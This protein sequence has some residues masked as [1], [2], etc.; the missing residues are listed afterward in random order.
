V[1][2]YDGLCRVLRDD[3]GLY[4]ATPAAADDIAGTFNHDKP[5]LTMLGNRRKPLQA[6]TNWLA[7][8]L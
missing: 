1:H 4:A 2:A 8:V 6:E 5:F 7:T 3:I